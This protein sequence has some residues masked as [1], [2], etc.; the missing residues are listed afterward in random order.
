M[1]L[2]TYLFVLKNK[3][4]AQSYSFAFIRKTITSIQKPY[5]L[6]PKRL[7]AQFM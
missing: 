3:I 4:N 1:G 7:I 6:I 5:Y 2:D